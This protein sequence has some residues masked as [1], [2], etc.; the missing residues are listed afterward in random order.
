MEARAVTI[1]GISITVKPMGTDYIM[2]DQEPDGIEVAVACRAYAAPEKWPN[3]MYVTYY[4]KLTEAYGACAILAWQ[5]KSVVGF[6]PFTPPGCGQRL[7]ACVHYVDEEDM[8]GVQSFVPV[9]QESLSPK[10]LKTHCLSVKGPLRRKGLGSQMVGCLVEWAR[11]NGWE[12]IEG[13]AFENGDYGWVPNIEFWEHCG[14]RRG[15]ARGWDEH[16]TDPGYEYSL[17]LQD[18]LIGHGS[19]RAD[20]P[21]PQ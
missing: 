6:L 21:G 20:A 19:G 11:A 17:E 4:R 3:P 13:W 10:L 12:R 16:I 14:F 18:R 15:K 8:P 5:E 9:P 1:E 2:A 7:P